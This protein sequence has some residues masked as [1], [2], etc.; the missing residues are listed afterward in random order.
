MTLRWNDIKEQ[1]VTV[2]LNTYKRP[3]MLQSRF[4]LKLTIAPQARV[5]YPLLLLNEQALW[6][7]TPGAPT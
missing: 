2:M 5:N 7:I 3:S 6:S 1:G 4:R